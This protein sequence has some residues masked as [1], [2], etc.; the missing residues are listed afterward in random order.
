VN[1]VNPH[2][3]MYVNTD[4]P[5]EK[6]QA[7][8]ML[9]HIEPAPNDPLYSTQWP[10]ELPKS[11]QQRL[12]AP[13]RPPAH[14]DYL[15]SHDALVG[16][17]ANEEWRWQYRHNYYLNCLRDVDRSIAPLLDELAALGLADNTIVVLT[18]DHGDLDGA[19]RL[20]SKGAT[21][22]RE[23]NNVPLIIAH[24]DHPGGKRCKAVTSHLDIAPTLLE[25]SGASPGKQAAIG[26]ALPGKSFAPL[27]AA[28]EQAQYTSV[29]DGALYCY[30]MFAY[31]DGEFMQKA[32]AMMQQPNGKAELKAAAQAGTMGPDL[33]KRGAIRSVYDG[34]YRFSR[35]FSPK[36]HNRPTTVEA[37]F[38]VNDVEL[39]DLESDP[40]EMNN[41]ALDRVRNQELIEAMNAKLNALIEREVGEDVGQMLPAGVNGGWVLT[42]A[43]YDV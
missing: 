18:A 41:L 17:I 14:A 25:L 42:D 29:R 33:R 8:D 9:G 35:Y 27:L 5:G 31:I 21:A 22:Y 43:V 30:N 26:K 36:Q 2:D 23:Q 11:Y 10:F 34:H 24:P 12:D 7:L 39:Y 13:G 19:H 38:E 20:H 15:R 40:L 37:L 16:H 28:P 1:L 6:V 4:R 32:V 3:I